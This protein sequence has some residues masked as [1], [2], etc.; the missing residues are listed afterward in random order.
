MKINFATFLDESKPFVAAST[1][2]CAY[3][4]PLGLLDLLENRLGLRGKLASAPQRVMQFYQLLQTLRE[5]QPTFYSDSFEKDPYG[6]AQ[7]LLGWRDDLVEAGWRGTCSD[8]DSPRL[9]DLA[10]IEARA[11]QELSPGVPDR[12]RRILEE[13]RSARIESLTVLGTRESLPPLWQ[14]LCARL[15]AEYLPPDSTLRSSFGEVKTDLGRLQ[16]LL[17]QTENCQ[18]GKP[19]LD[20][21]GSL[22]FLT[23]YSESTLARA[24]AQMLRDLRRETSRS[25]R[26]IKPGGVAT[27]EQALAALD[28]PTL[29]VAAYSTARTI[30]QLLL[31]ALRLYWA[32]RDPRAVLEFLTHPACPVTGFLR[33]RLAKAVASSPGF[34]GPAWQAAIDNARDSAKQRNS[35]DPE[36]L[37]Q[38]NRRIDQDLGQWLAVPQFD[39]RDGAPGKVVTECCRQVAQW[40]GSRGSMADAPDR[41]AFNALAGL[42]SEMADLAIQ[43]PKISRSQLEQMLDQVTAAGWR[44]AALTSELGHVPWVRSPAAILEPV[45]TVIWW[46]FAEE[47]A[48]LRQPWTESELSQLS[49]H[50]VQLLTSAQ[51]AAR[52]SQHW[53]R[54]V[55][56]ARSKLVFA[57]PRVRA[58]EPVAPHQLYTRIRSLIATE[59]GSLPTVDLDQ[60]ISS[61]TAGAPFAVDSMKHRPLPALRRWWKLPSGNSLEPRTQESY[62]SAEKFIYSPYAWVLRYKARLQAGPVAS[63]RVADH[64]SLKGRLLHRV[65]DLLLATPVPEID[66][67]TANRA[68]LAEW[69]ETRW[70]NLLEQEGALL[71]LPGHRTEA[72]DLLETCAAALWELLLQLRAAHVIQAQSNVELTPKG[73]VGGSMM[74]TLDL[75]VENEAGRTAVLDLK[76]GG[77]R[78]REGELKDNRQLQL[79]VYAFLLRENGAAHWPEGGF[80]LLKDRR[81]IAQPGHF[82]PGAETVRPETR[83]FGLERCW[84]TFEQVWVWRRKQLDA[85]WIE[86]TASGTD[87]GIAPA[88]LSEPG[89]PIPEWAASEEHATF[90]DYD[91]LTGWRAEV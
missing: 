4:G 3:C 81:L 69:I 28:E 27:L 84:L 46:D 41:A 37:K 56:G 90:N 19:A 36:Q 16:S 76:F 48:Q 11:A 6:V 68:A 70:D 88:G 74:G 23:A 62:S 63:L 40:A 43:L 89:P 72:A 53:L 44:N 45:D 35:Q 54:P 8:S 31:L 58:G 51:T 60:V 25:V 14:A 15:A 34:G 9:R 55:F 50:G 80:Y 33:H 65:L 5:E 12:L 21:D 91:A 64:H 22:L 77:A 39:P 59:P 32:P 61:G 30:P 49:A 29:G 66:W 83:E 75:L 18:G 57:C 52:A 67:R 78:I 73:F 71:R 26:L 79:A 38:Q 10:A 82:F 85:G 47:P 20:A 7:T 42:A 1:L 86:V 13:N 87:P 24:V 17:R 2:D